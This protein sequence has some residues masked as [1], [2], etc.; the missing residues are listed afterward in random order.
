MTIKRIGLIVC[1]VVIIL[2]C[3]LFS[4]ADDN[5]TQQMAQKAME[6]F[7]AKKYDEAITVL[8]ELVKE[9]PDDEVALYNIACAY[10]LL[11][12]PDDAMAYL[13]KSVEAGFGDFEL[14]Q[15][16]PDLQCLRNLD[17]YKKLI[18]SKELY[19]KKAADKKLS[20]LKKQYGE[21]YIYEI[22]DKRKLIYASAASEGLLNKIQDF[23]NKFADGER[24]YLFKNKPSYYITIL[25]PT[26]KDFVKLVP[27]PR[28][29]GFY[30]HQI[31]TL[32]CRDTDMTL[33]HEFTHA[34]HFADISS[35]RQ[36][37][38]IWIAEGLST[39]FEDSEL[40]NGRVVPRY[41]ERI[42]QMKELIKNDRVIP[43]ET[44]ANMDHKEFMQK[45][46]E[47]YAEVRA[48]FYWM[49]KNDQLKTFYYTYLNDLFTNKDNFNGMATMQKIYGK[50]IELIEND[51]KRWVTK[52]ATDTEV[53]DNKKGTYL[54]VA[55]NPS[56]AGMI[57]T[58]VAAG[59]PAEQAGLKVNDVILKIGTD[60]VDNPEKFTNA[61]R[62]RSPG[63]IST[64]YILRDNVEKQIKVKFG[65]KT[66]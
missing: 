56:V 18:Q 42:N 3:P 28:I 62:E 58:N 16:D 45:A 1:L 15:S 65:K 48:I 2:A 40:V 14:I 9:K 13:Q 66:K 30:A 19:Q 17:G 21:G 61:I 41:N 55:I 12:K 22:D 11:K 63:D 53:M 57:I 39:C 24:F 10:A 52:A 33:R 32:I 31:K 8:Q 26:I 29:G 46:L 50:K 35:R 60:K 34:L 4:S 27:D 43:W 36:T 44:L 23:L 54:G 51:W 5:E 6:L 20:E 49:D 38:P 37:H 47:C 7:Q 64:F 25:V 59:S